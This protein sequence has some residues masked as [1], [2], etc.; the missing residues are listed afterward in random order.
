MSEL[1]ARLELSPTA[2]VILRTTAA[3]LEPATLS[4]SI[5]KG[6]PAEIVITWQDDRAAVKDLS[7]ESGTM[8]IAESWGQTVPDLTL[9]EE[10]GIEL[11][12][13]MD[14]ANVRVTVTAAQIAAMPFPRMVYRLTVAGKALLVGHITVR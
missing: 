8:T 4:L 9:D 10:D 13:G 12:D 6:A 11:S 3:T 2:G 5:A 1:R 14:G 7:A